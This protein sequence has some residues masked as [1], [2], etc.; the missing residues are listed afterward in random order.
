[1]PGRQEPKTTSAMQTQ[2]RPLTISKKN[3]LNADMVRKAPPTAISAEP[4]ATAPMRI[5]VTLR[6]WASSASGFSPATRTAR[7]SGV[8]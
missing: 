4:A 8:R 1:M 2:P 5:A 6:P 3:E 7:P